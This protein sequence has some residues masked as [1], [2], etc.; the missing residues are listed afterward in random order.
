[1]PL[2]GDFIYVQ[3]NS[4]WDLSEPP[5]NP[6]LKPSVIAQVCLHLPHV[7]SIYIWGRMKRGRIPSLSLCVIHQQNDFF[8]QTHYAFKY[9]SA[10]KRS[11]LGY[12]CILGDTITLESRISYKKKAFQKYKIF[13]IFI[14]LALED[15][16]NITEV[17][18]FKK[19][20]WS[21]PNSWL[22]QVSWVSTCVRL[23]SNVSL[24]YFFSSSQRRRKNRDQRC[25]SCDYGGE[26]T[27][28]NWI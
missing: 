18:V 17:Y 27:F 1:M 12:Q 24:G 19:I 28:P 3:V 9:H 10:S 20:K 7:G 15:F 26:K 14:F 13:W 8:L 16:S 5:L 23:N 11:V 21:K 6:F 2:H 22:H 4:I 25:H